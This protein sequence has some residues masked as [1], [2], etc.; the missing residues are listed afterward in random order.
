MRIVKL[1]GTKKKAIV[2]RDQE[3]EF[4]VLFEREMKPDFWYAYATARKHLIHKSKKEIISELK[5]V[6]KEYTRHVREFQLSKL[7]KSL[8]VDRL[9]LGN[10]KL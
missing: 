2:T 4:R 3:K 5:R 1:H 9:D 6:Q 8:N 7:M 10:L